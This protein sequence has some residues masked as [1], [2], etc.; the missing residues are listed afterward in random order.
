MLETQSKAQAVGYPGDDVGCQQAEH[1]HFEA[2]AIQDN[3]R[4]E[5]RLAC[6]FVDDIGGQY[7]HFY[8]GKHA[9]EHLATRFNVVISNANHIVREVVEDFGNQVGMFRILIGTILKRRALHVVSIVQKNQFVAEF[10]FHLFDEESVVGEF[11]VA[12]MRVGGLDDS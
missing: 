10:S 8:L 12:S 9:V 3:I 7:G 5:I 1:S 11:V 2:V 6:F 4:C